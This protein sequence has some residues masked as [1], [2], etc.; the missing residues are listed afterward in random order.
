MGHLPFMLHLTIPIA[1]LA[2]DNHLDNHSTTLTVNV[3]TG[4]GLSPR[5]LTR[6]ALHWVCSGNDP[7]PPQV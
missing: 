6:R 2:R 1:R 3:G 7:L 5:A 4:I